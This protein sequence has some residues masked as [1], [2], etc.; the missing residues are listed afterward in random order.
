MIFKCRSTNSQLVEPPFHLISKDYF[1]ILLLSL[2]L[3]WRAL[4]RMHRLFLPHC[5]KSDYSSKY[6]RGSAPDF[7]NVYVLENQT[8]YWDHE[9]TEFRNKVQSV[10]KINV[11]YKAILYKSINISKVEVRWL[12]ITKGWL[13]ANI[14]YNFDQN[15]GFE[16]CHVLWVSTFL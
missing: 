2:V 10:L 12:F 11:W 16:N 6:F 13:V 1:F 7:K 3:L 15:C 9:F 4:T 8:I 14:C 5:T